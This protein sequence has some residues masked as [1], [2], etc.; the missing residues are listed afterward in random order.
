MWQKFIIQALKDVLAKSE[1][2]TAIF[3]A[4][5]KAVKDTKNPIDDKAAQIVKSVYDVIIGVL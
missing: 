5:D 1:T 2:K 4:I 3:K